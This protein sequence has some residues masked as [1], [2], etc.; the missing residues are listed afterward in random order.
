MLKDSMLCLNIP[1]SSRFVSLQAAQAP[2]IASYEYEEVLNDERR[3]LSKPKGG[4]PQGLSSR[5]YRLSHREGLYPVLAH[6]THTQF[7]RV[8]SFFRSSS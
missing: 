2:H 7:W 1:L 8:R 4:C 3:I 6:S 5:V